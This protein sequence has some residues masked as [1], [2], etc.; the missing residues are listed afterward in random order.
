M[1]VIED[2]AVF[3]GLTDRDPD[4][5]LREAKALGADAVRVYISW[6][7]ATSAISTQYAPPADFVPTDHQNG[8]YDWRPYDQTIERAR[9]HGLKVII[10]IGPAMP[11]WAS[12]EPTRCPHPVGNKPKLG[13]GCY[14]K[15]NPAL[16]GQFVGA[17]ASRYRGKASFYSLWNEPNLENYLLPQRQKTS[18]GIV[19][20]GGKQLRELYLAGYRAIR[21]RDPRRAKHVLFGETSAIS[22]PRDTL[23]SALCLNRRGRPYKG[24]IKAAQGCSKPGKLPIGGLAVHPYNQSARGS[25]FSTSK[26][27]ASMPMAYLSRADRLLALAEKYKRVPKGRGIYITEFGFQS[28]PA[29]ALGL[30]L[31]AQAKELNQS[32]RLFFDDKRIKSVAQF[33]LYDVPDRPGEDIFNTGLRQQDGQAKPSLAAWRLPLVVTPQELPPGRGLG[34]GAPGPRPRAGHGPGGRD[35]P[36][37]V[38]HA[39]AGAHQP[40]RLLPLRRPPVAC[41]QA[42][43]PA[44]LGAAPEPRGQ[45]RPQDQ[46]QARLKATVKRAHLRCRV[47]SRHPRRDDSA[48]DGRARRRAGPEA[49]VR[50]T[51]TSASVTTDQAACR[52]LQNGRYAGV[53]SSSYSSLKKLMPRSSIRASASAFRRVS[54]LL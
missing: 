20:M 36:G 6:R 34:P 38:P 45:A 49:R 26:T 35:G 31:E 42:Q 7:R 13:L 23:F 16:F 51:A 37:P 33:E 50:R 29:N 10:S 5:A 9:A 28:R 8:W 40:R 25:V 54:S 21:A 41:R 44:E 3:L 32:E 22:S 14:W 47:R 24:A 52:G 30:S 53:P 15:P 46:V 39:Q 19:D 4:A 11:Y 17:V 18:A 12:L 27:K 2:G 48:H 1:S 43:L